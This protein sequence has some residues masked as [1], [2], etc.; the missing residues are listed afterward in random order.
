MIL[1]QL[2]QWMQERSHIRQALL[3]GSGDAHE[4]LLRKKQ[5]ERQLM[6]QAA[7]WRHRYPEVTAL[8]AASQYTSWADELNTRW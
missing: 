3:Q 8:P 6:E 4:L 7:R 5:L 1:Y 2:T